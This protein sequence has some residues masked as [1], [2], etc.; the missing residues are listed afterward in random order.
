[1]RFNKL[2]Y[3][4]GLYIFLTQS[5]RVLGQDVNLFD[6]P[7]NNLGLQSRL[8]QPMYDNYQTV[9][10]FAMVIVS[11]LFLLYSFQ[12]YNKMQMGETKVVPMMTRFF[13]GLVVFIGMLSFLNKFAHKQDYNGN[14]FQNLTMPTLS[15]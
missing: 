5:S 12:I 13:L 6:S 15:K 1:M 11:V 8:T 7:S 3:L 4:F 9:G 2:F 10:G 14:S